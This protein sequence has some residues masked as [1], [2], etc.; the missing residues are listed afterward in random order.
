MI[1]QHIPDKFKLGTSEYTVHMHDSINHKDGGVQYGCTANFASVI[2]LAKGYKYKDDI[3]NERLLEGNFNQDT[4]DNTFYHELAHAI[5]NQA[6]IECE[7]EAKIQAIANLL[8]QYFTQFIN[9][10]N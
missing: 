8:H 2:D 10:F 9:K 7:D 3:L 1:S 5:F 6:C 4:I